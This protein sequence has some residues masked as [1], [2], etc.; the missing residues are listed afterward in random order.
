MTWASGFKSVG[1]RSRA[2]APLAQVSLSSLPLS[3]NSRSL[4]CA[5]TA[6]FLETAVTGEGVCAPR[7]LAWSRV[8]PGAL[9][10]AWRGWG[11]GGLPGSSCEDA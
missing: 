4:P 6:P 2:W 10:G 7:A 3:G 5:E 1:K 9:Q 8:T 11:G